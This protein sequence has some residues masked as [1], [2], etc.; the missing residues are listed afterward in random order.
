[1]LSFGKHTEQVNATQ[2]KFIIVNLKKVRSY[3][4]N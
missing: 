3:K 2:H 4:D 1:M